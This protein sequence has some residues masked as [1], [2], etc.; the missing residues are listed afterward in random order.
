MCTTI[1]LLILA[2][3]FRILRWLRGDAW[4]VTYVCG[5]ILNAYSYMYSIYV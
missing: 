3:V 2:T 1:E 5:H 4:G